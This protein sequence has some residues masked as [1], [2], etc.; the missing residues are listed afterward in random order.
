MQSSKRIC[1]VEHFEDESQ[2]SQSQVDE[3]TGKVVCRQNTDG[4]LT[5]DEIRVL[6]GDVYIMKSRG[7]RTWVVCN[8]SREVG[9]FQLLTMPLSYSNNSGQVV[10]VHT[11]M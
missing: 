3:N 9:E 5:K 10:H 11:H 4:D 7:P 8:R 2:M 6:R 1:V